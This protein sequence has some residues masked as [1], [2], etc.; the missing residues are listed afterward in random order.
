MPIVDLEHIEDPYVKKELTRLNKLSDEAEVHH[1]TA[2]FLM[3]LSTASYLMFIIALTQEN[4]RGM[5]LALTGAVVGWITANY[6]QRKATNIMEKV[7]ADGEELYRRTVMK[8][9]TPAL[10]KKLIEMIEK[11]GTDA[12]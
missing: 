2:M 9:L 10:K 6:Y 1:K 12:K 8:N 4:N 5:W 7:L 3:V 11:E